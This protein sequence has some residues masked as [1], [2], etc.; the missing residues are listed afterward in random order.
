MQANKRF[1]WTTLL[2]LA[3]GICLLVAGCS[4]NNGSNNG[5]N[6]SNGSPGSSESQQPSQSGADSSPAASE[7]KPVKLVWYMRTA[8]PTNADKVLAKANE[9]IQ[10]EINATLEMKWVEPGDYVQKM[11]LVMSSGEAYDLAFTSSWSNNYFD[12]VSRGAYVPLDDLL[13]QYPDT[14]SL[15][16]P[17]ILDAV[18]VGGKLYAIPNN[19]TMT[20]Y[21]GFVF[22]KSLVDKYGIDLSTVKSGTDL[23]PIFQK[24]KDNEPDI[25]PLQTGA[26][27]VFDPVVSTVEGFAVNTDTGEV[28][29]REAQNLDEYKLFKEWNEKGFFPPDVA[30]LKDFEPLLKAGQIFSF[31]A[32]MKPG[33][34]AE[35]LGKYGYEW[36]DYPVS[37]PVI[38]RDAVTAGLTAISA[39]SPNPDRAMMLINLVNTNKEL[40]NLLT[41]GIEGEDYTKV[42]DNHIEKIDGTYRVSG[43]L[44]GNVFNN[45]LLPGQPDDLWEQTQKANDS[46]LID[47]L[48]SFSFD[49]TPVENEI[50]LINST[51]TQFSPILSNGLDDPEKI[52]KQRD[53]KMAASGRDKVIAEI[54]KQLDAW[55]ASNPQ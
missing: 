4:G 21:V 8:E 53:E 18:R 24:I 16:Q 46:A 43:W 19:Q 20:N 26:S 2:A 10:K 5:S 38:N 31:S 15:F 39:T 50:A 40:F 14:K 36:V 6:G 22:M 1:K 44:L 42:S 52:L 34:A 29:D 49:R 32:R 9:I 33:N 35:M 51:R 30:T 37:T 41:Y 28:Y 48:I 54:K 55:R 47:P 12:N 17:G 7:L 13:E 45:Y 23:T 11:Q 27:F 3:I 25:I